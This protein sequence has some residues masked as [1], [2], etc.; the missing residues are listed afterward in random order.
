M[1]SVFA[2]ESFKQ[3]DY[4]S[5]VQGREAVYSKVY[6]LHLSKIEWKYVVRK[7][8]RLDIIKD[9]HSLP[10]CSHFVKHYGEYKNTI[11]LK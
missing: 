4:V 2:S 5:S 6:S 1:V 10:L 8:Q 7:S 3:S 9:F 11:Y